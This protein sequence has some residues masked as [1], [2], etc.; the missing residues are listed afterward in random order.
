MDPKTAEAHPTTRNPGTTADASFSIKPLI[1]KYTIPSVRMIKGSNISF[2]RIPTVAL[3]RPI[4]RA[5]IKAAP[6]LSTWMPGSTWAT[7][8]RAMPLSSQ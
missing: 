1:R 7:I 8:T 3:T 2:R 4:T 5:A 6:K